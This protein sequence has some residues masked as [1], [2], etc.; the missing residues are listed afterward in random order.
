MPS[1]RTRWAIAALSILACTPPLA[2]ADV[3]SFFWYFNEQNDYSIP[4]CNTLII[5]FATNPNA[6]IKAAPP[7][8][9]IAYPAGSTPSR[10]NA[11]LGTS[12]GFQ[13]QVAYPIG[14]QLLLSF[15][16]SAGNSGGVGPLYSIVTG[17]NSCSS[18]ASSPTPLSLTLD[19]SSQP[20]TC[21]NVSVQAS[22]G[23]PPYT[24]TRVI[25]AD[26]SHNTTF[27][28]PSTTFQN[29]LSAGAG[30][31]ASVSD[32]QGRY[33]NSTSLIYSG[34]GSDTSCLVSSSSSTGGS[35][36]NATSSGQTSGES[37]STAPKEEAHHSYPAVIGGIVAGLGIAAAAAVFLYYQRRNK[38]QQ[39]QLQAGKHHNDGHGGAQ[40]APSGGFGG[41]SWL[42]K[43]GGG[44]G[45]RGPSGGMW[46][47]E[48]I[49]E[50]PSITS[51]PVRFR[52]TNPDDDAQSQ[53]SLPMTGGGGPRGSAD[54]VRSS[55]RTTGLE[56]PELHLPR[57]AYT[58]GMPSAQRQSLIE[59][60]HNAL[61]PPTGSRFSAATAS[62]F[63]RARS[64]TMSG[65]SSSSSSSTAAAA[66][67]PGDPWPTY[68]S[69]SSS[70]EDH[71]M[72]HPASSAG[73]LSNRNSSEQPRSASSTTAPLRSPMSTWRQVY[74]AEMMASSSPHSPSSSSSF[75]YIANIT[76]SPPPPPPPPFFRS[77][78]AM[79]SSS[80]ALGSPFADSQRVRETTTS[81]LR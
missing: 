4:Q 30:F 26:T 50:Y 15:V 38:R 37:G 72:D 75:A 65:G 34:G 55:A 81:V 33:A 69:T 70:T 74:P 63:A 49:T 36:G 3:L 44:E 79:S 31:L 21:Q 43:G 22:G 60:D 51:G 56:S 77:D 67:E 14:T 45:K 46:R 2:K 73:I 9:L 58:P 42:S 61:Y 32:S 16:D 8:V 27:T 25:S 24:L 5:N 19:P 1:P 40:A 29:T 35:G 68:A 52:V 11:G 80:N 62:S 12:Q 7:Y 66:D 57:R 64:R 48:S 17:S 41:I 6:T 18:Y 59:A 10:F 76:P 39:A 13:W 28:G 78:T 20:S 23:T 47:P 54:T 71:Y 53:F